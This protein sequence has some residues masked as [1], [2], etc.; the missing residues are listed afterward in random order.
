MIIKRIVL[1]IIAV[2]LVMTTL[3]SCTTKEEKKTSDLG[4]WANNFVEYEGWVYYSEWDS[5]DLYKIKPS[6]EDKTR[7]GDIKTYYFRIYENRIFCIDAKDGKKGMLYSTNME[8]SDIIFL[9]GAEKFYIV[10][11]WV[12]SLMWHMVIYKA[13]L[14]GTERTVLGLGN[15]PCN[16]FY[17]DGEWIYFSI[18]KPIDKEWGYVLYKMHMDG[19]QRTQVMQEVGLTIDYDD[20]WFYYLDS[21]GIDLYSME[22][23]S[24]YKISLNSEKKEKITDCKSPLRGFHKVI[25][26][27]LYYEDY[28]D[29]DG[30]YKVKTDNGE[31]VKIA[32]FSYRI[33]GVGIWGNWMVYQC[34]DLDNEFYTKYI[35]MVRI[36]DSEKTDELIDIIIN[37]MEQ[38]IEVRKYDYK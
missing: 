6:G 21:A 37:D 29:E 35:Q 11:G 17:I 26:D 33:S 10:D 16:D 12:Y 19:T 36:S 38:Y 25:G 4:L 30:F 13:R 2:L 24:I 31:R 8:G 22:R 27:W 5:G 1:L 32:D 14:D 9:H 15:E 28:D 7:V 20:E 34:M 23:Q 3:G 18:W